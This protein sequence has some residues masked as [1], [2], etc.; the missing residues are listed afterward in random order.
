MSE[1]QTEIKLLRDCPAILIPHGI[2]ITMVK[3]EAVSIMQQL[4]GSFTVY[5]N[6]NLA[7]I[8]GKD[9][10]AIGKAI[11]SDA[12]QS[13]ETTKIEKTIVDDGLVDED[14]VWAKL[15]TCYDPEI[16]VNIVELGLIYECDVYP[17]ESG[18]IQ[19]GNRVEVK[20]TLTAPGCG[21]GPYIVSDVNKKV[22]EVP[23]VFEAKVELI[24]DPPWSQDMM[25]EEAQLTLGLL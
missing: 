4:G 5:Y 21:M 8:D 9:A 18:N 17:I 13:I 11:P 14:E 20:M 2:P 15:R 12:A 19:A 24:W 7:R 1:S 23:N 6:G 3:D 10:D 22:L 16:P 25:S